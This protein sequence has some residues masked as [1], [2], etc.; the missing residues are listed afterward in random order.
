MLLGTGDL[1]IFAAQEMGA[2]V[3]AV[4]F[5][6]GM[7]QLLHQRL[8]EMPVPVTAHVMDGQNL[9]LEDSIFDVVHSSFGVTL[10]PD[11]RMV[12]L[13]S[14]TLTALRLQGMLLDVLL[15]VVLQFYTCVI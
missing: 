12:C 2:L 5:S 6:P 14:N 4:D 13:I 7:I 9:E 1:A 3:T 15:D 10:F 8:A 11:F